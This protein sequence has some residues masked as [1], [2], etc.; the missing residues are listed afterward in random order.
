[1]KSHIVKMWDVGNGVCVCVYIFI[2]QSLSPGL[3]WPVVK[4]F[5]LVLWIR[6][7]RAV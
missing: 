4:T 2:L 1:M 7:R 3:D 5:V 6:L